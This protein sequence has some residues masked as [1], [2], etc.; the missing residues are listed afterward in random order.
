LQAVPGD[1]GE[2]DGDLWRA[3]A[4][5]PEK[6][7]QAMAYHYI[8]GLAHAEVAGILGGTPD[9]ARRDAA[10]GARNLRKNYPGT[11]TGGTSS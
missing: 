9:T 6:Q 3:V 4:A 2:E 5:L 11:P 10:D 7:R 1:P 8:A